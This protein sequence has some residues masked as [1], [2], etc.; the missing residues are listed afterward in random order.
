MPDKDWYRNCTIFKRIC[1]HFR[2]P[3]KDVGRVVIQGVSLVR[4]NR[5][6]VA[7]EGGGIA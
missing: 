5:F 6:G 3:G 1:T 4:G 7:D 2:V